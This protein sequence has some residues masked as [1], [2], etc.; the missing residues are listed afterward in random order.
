[1]LERFA[2][3]FLLLRHLGQGGMGE[4]FL[5]RD[6]TTGIECALKR[7]RTRAG[8]GIPETARREFEAVTRVRHPV[9]VSV[10]EFGVSPDGVPFCAMEYVPGVSAVHAV[11]RGDWGALCFVG[12]R[13]ARG[14]E[15]LHRAGVVHGDIK[16]A[17]LLMIPGE[18]A[19]DLPRSVRLVDFGLAVLAG[20]VQGGHTGTPGYAAPEVVGGQVPSPA[21]D[22]YSLGATL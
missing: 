13:V 10:Y 11:S 17:N 7:L 1:M 6:L 15:A 3:R 18:N 8:N 16:P 19:G 4:V 9:L 22:L 20:E 12:A 21:A 5:A 14:L 2:G